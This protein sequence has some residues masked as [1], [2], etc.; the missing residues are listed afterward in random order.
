[1]VNDTQIGP[2]AHFLQHGRVAL[3]E[4]RAFGDAWAGFAR[5][6]LA[7]SRPILAEV[8]D[9]MGKALGR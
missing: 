3:S 2:I 5:L 8:I 4:G 1:M 6:N 7:T 9:R